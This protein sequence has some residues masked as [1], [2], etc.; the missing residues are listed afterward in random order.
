MTK[1]IIVEDHSLTRLGIKTAIETRH[2]DLLV[3]GDVASGEEFFALLADVTPDIILL[4]IELPDMSG[5]DIARRLKTERP[6]IKILTISAEKTAEAIRA[7]HE[8][9][10]DGFIGKRRGGLDMFAEAIRTVMLGEKYYGADISEIMYSVYV[11]KK[12]TAE[13]TSE[14]TPQEGRIIQLCRKGTPA[15]LI[16]DELGIS[17][18][19]VHVHKNS[20]FKKLGVKSTAELVHCIMKHN[21]YPTE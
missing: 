13:V 14:F 20:I 2:P 15:K 21:L 7:M 5:I 18:N 19:T 16:A 11:A 1:V 6:E 8:V 17:I 12:K 4:D 3:V 9:G 10:V